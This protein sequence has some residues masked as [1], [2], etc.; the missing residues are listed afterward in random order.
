[1]SLKTL[2]NRLGAYESEGAD[3]DASGAA[4]AADLDD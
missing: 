3:A 2:Y 4:G 1:V